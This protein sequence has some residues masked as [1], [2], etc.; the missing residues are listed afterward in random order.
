[1]QWPLTG[2]GQ[3]GGRH[4][5]HAARHV[6]ALGRERVGHEDTRANLLPAELRI[7]VEAMRE[8]EQRRPPR[9]D[10]GARR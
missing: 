8:V 1:M 10:A 3:E 7:G 9:L 5:G 4:R 6:E 2:P